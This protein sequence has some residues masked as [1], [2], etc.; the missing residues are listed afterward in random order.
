MWSGDLGR[1]MKTD[2]IPALKK[3]MQQKFFE[4]TCST[5]LKETFYQ[6]ELSRP[7]YPHVQ[8]LLQSPKWTKTI[9]LTSDFFPVAP[10]QVAFSFSLRFISKLTN[11]TEY[12]PWNLWLVIPSHNKATECFDFWRK[13]KMTNWGGRSNKMLP[14]FRYL[15]TVNFTI[16]PP[17][18]NF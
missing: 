16:V 1:A 11:C 14:V 4:N 2:V 17:M 3:R 12:F 9:T 10:I 18:N 7:R 5:F 15:K 13:K 6:G 8:S